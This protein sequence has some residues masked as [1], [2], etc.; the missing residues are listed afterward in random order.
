MFVDRSTYKLALLVLPHPD[1]E[2]RE[3]RPSLLMR[4][5]CTAMTADQSTITNVAANTA[6]ST[7][8]ATR[9][10]VAE[11]SPAV[12]PIT[13]PHTTATPAASPRPARFCSRGPNLG[14]VER[15]IH[16]TR[17]ATYASVRPIA[18]PSSWTTRPINCHTAVHPMPA[19]TDA[20][21]HV[22]EF[23]KPTPLR[24]I[25]TVSFRPL[26]SSDKSELASSVRFLRPAKRQEPM[27]P[28]R[29]LPSHSPP[30]LAL[31]HVR[32][33]S[34]Q[35]PRRLMTR[36][37]IFGDRVIVGPPPHLPF[38]GPVTPAPQNQPGCR[39]LLAQ[40]CGPNPNTT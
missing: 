2:F 14:F 27:G 22:R 12:V 35:F 25:L 17:P 4:R 7:A 32:L 19:T 20:I 31:R 1:V 6:N 15:T 29:R 33:E 13:T 28:V 23:T 21:A 40:P 34:A 30:W 36:V 5:R 37:T 10:A 9:T 8:T 38:T 39:T 18:I 3:V 11:S 16:P 26:V 24:D